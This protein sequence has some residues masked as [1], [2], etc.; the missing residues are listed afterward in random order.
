M[1]RRLS[2][3]GAWPRSGPAW[4]RPPRS[5]AGRRG[6]P[7]TG[8]GRRG[9]ARAAADRRGPPRA[10]AGRPHQTGLGGACTPSNRGLVPTGGASARNR[11]APSLPWP[12]KQARPRQVPS[13][14]RPCPPARGATRGRV[15]RRARN[16]RHSGRR[17]MVAG[18]GS[19]G[20]PALLLAGWARPHRWPSD[21]V[22][23]T[24]PG[25]RCCCRGG[26]GSIGGYLMLLGGL[27]GPPEVRGGC[28][29]RTWMGCLPGSGGAGRQRGT[30]RHRRPRV[31]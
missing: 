20:G 12:S 25:H 4:R 24:S 23:V 7:R 29:A 16:P 17:G 1:T 28:P 26:A 3:Y 21:A 19:I 30:L 2:G 5:G 18:A 9:P 10:V 22:P 27:R 14:P 6:P 8:A 13:A 31:P 15:P 11:R